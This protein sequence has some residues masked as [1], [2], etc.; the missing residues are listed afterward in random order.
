MNIESD[1]LEQLFDT[2]F[3]N[4]HQKAGKIL[5][6]HF[7][8]IHQ[9]AGNP[10]VP[11]TAHDWL[12]IKNLISSKDAKNRLIAL[13]LIKG[14]Q[15][16]EE[17]LIINIHTCYKENL[18]D[19]FEHFD[20]F[21]RLI[22]RRTCVEIQLEKLEKKIEKLTKYATN[23]HNNRQEFE[24]YLSELKD[25]YLQTREELLCPTDYEYIHIKKIEQLLGEI[26]GISFPDKGGIKFKLI[27][28]YHNLFYQ[29]NQ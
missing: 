16:S 24:S 1:F 17:E 11:S 3:N 6:K 7:I 5:L 19:L 10:P 23:T 13:H 21:F 4:L 20:T 25:E 15:L 8:Q 26:F 29:Q 14:F 28:K 18:T 27:D 9:L 12:H 22:D 2:L